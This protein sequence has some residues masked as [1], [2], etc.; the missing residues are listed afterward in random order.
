MVTQKKR[1]YR[2]KI[3]SNLKAHLD[4]KLVGRGWFDNVA[5]GETD[6]G[7]NNLS[8]LLPVQNDPSYPLDTGTTVHVW[9]GYRRNWVSESG[10]VLWASGISDPTIPRSVF[11]SG[12]SSGVKDFG[13][14]V[15]GLAIDFRNGRVLF[16]TPILA[17]TTIEVAHSYKDVWVDTLSRDMIT[18]QVTSV[19]N[20]KRIII[21]NVPSGEVGQLP[22]ILMEIADS[23]SPVG[24]ELGGGLIM[25]PVVHLHVVAENR[26]DKDELIDFL[27]YQT[28]KTIRMIDYDLAPN[29]FTY[30]GDFATTWEKLTDLT[31]NYQG[32][33]IWFKGVTLVNSDDIAEDGYY[34]ALVKMELEIHTNEVL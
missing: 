3:Y 24:R 6:W 34:T 10:V 23:P 21:N 13:D 27:Q 8:Q 19:D 28:H 15:S 31:T 14:T 29:Q 20:T 2:N 12:V 17:T 32:S 26:Y 5:S 33:Q 7:S 9:Q 4:D 11:V 1:G 16:E 25:S 22:M 30:E 18:T